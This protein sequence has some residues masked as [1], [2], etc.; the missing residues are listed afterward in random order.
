M[1]R[2][3]RKVLPGDPGFGDPLSTAGKGGPARIA[4]VADR[5]FDPAPG[6]TREV[7][8]GGLQVWQ[9]ILEKC[10]RGRGEREVTIVFT[11]LVGFS[12]W[13]LEVG[14][15]ATLTLL[16]LVAQT[17]ETAITDHRGTVV[18]RMGDGIM[19]VFPAPCLALDAMI[20]AR[21]K[22][23]RVEIG[24]YRPY[25]RVGIHTGSPR[26]IG[27]DWLGVDVNV[28]ARVM[29][30]GGS[31]NLMMSGHALEVLGEEEL[32]RRG[33]FARPHRRF[34]KQKMSGVPSDVRIFAIKRIK[35][36]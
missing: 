11:D 34:F 13:A 8:L 7:S 21:T 30:A 27:D 3:I 1:T 31:G 32:K 9:S 4:R 2:R 20:D 26:P 23:K 24:G 10:G 6:A 29:E 16:R 28:A 5:F 36:D 33:V 12:A 18:K 14:D 35:S 19:A 25:M 22:L 15:D 17:V